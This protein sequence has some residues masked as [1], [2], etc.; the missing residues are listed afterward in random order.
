MIYLNYITTYC[1]ICIISVTDCLDQFLIFI[2][3][4]EKSCVG[5]LFSFYSSQGKSVRT[6]YV[7]L[8]SCTW[9][10]NTYSTKI[11][12]FYDSCIIFHPVKYELVRYLN[13]NDK[14][15]RCGAWG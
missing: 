7:R 14:N 5:P 13:R 6:L 4:E 8:I 11:L 9:Y 2:Y 12:Y 10:M 3:H 1:F 15:R